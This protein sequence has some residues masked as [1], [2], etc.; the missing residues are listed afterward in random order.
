MQAV[1]GISWPENPLRDSIQRLSGD[2]QVAMLLDRNVDPG[3][4]IE[5]SERGATLEQTLEHL[6]K[7]ANLAVCRVGPV[8]YF[9]PKPIAARTP[10]LAD[11][12]TEEA[13]SLP[14]AAAARVAQRRPAAWEQLAEPRA[15]VE[16][17]AADYGLRVVGSERIPHDLWPAADLPPLSFTERMTLLLAGFQL[18]FQWAP[19]GTA[20]RV[21]DV[22]DG[23]VVERSYDAPDAAKALA[24]VQRKFPGAG[25]QRTSSGVRVAATFAEHF[26]VE[27]L[28]RGAAAPVAVKPPMPVAGRTTYTLKVENIR[29][30]AV[31]ERVAKD[32]EW[33]LQV[34][35]RAADALNGRVSFDVKDVS[36]DELMSRA[37]T[38]VGL[39]YRAV[40][41]KLEILP[42]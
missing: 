39:T 3:R 34:D 35:P 13:A 4:K 32:Q 7:Q 27:R 17:A 11:L 37:L 40:D 16:L 30:R 31:V 10:V 15:L 38:P 36:L 29:A 24:E 5:I 14:P 6:A 41:G 20:I 1:I 21:G 26:E 25:A 12:R 22:D 9:A 8:V 18:T 23:A 2:Q 42:K 33:E 19:D 28:L